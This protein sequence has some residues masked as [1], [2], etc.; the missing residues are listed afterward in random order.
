LELLLERENWQLA[1]EFLQEWGGMILF[2]L[3]LQKDC[4]WVRRLD[5]ATRLRLP[6]MVAFLAGAEDPLAL[7]ERL[8]VPR[9]QHLLLSQFV[10]LRRR[11]AQAE[12]LPLELQPSTSWQWC[13]LLE[14]P[15]LA[16]VAALAPSGP[17]VFRPG[18][19]GGRCA[20]GPRSWSPA[21]PLPPAPAGAGK[22][23]ISPRLFQ[24][25]VLTITTTSPAPHGHSHCSQVQL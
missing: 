1:L 24:T 15:G 10:D 6:R 4:Y 14:A 12:L 9:R 11:L 18:A 16:V 7:A 17:G 13:Q 19:H 20:E 25:W 23:L 2:D 8:Q 22:A 5:W 3:N 21:P